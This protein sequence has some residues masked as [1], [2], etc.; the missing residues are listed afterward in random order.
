MIRLSVLSLTTLFGLLAVSA[1]AE[2]LVMRDGQRV[3]TAG[4]WKVQGRVVVFERATGGLVSVRSDTVDLA[5]SRA[6]LSQRGRVEPSAPA[7]EDSRPVRRASRLRLTNDDVRPAVSEAADRRVS[8]EAAE[9]ARRWAR[10]RLVV[11]TWARAE[12]PGG[13]GIE[14]AGLLQNKSAATVEVTDVVVDLRGS[15][16][17]IIATRRTS[18]EEPV[19]APGDATRFRVAFHD[20]RAVDGQP[21][22]RVEASESSAAPGTGQR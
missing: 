3:E 7:P 20:A 14:I 4:P 5:A 18:P 1:S 19:L 8:P 17:E 21:D 13:L 15:G 2:V 11:D 9:R 6:A 10:S 22:F 12:L 16:G